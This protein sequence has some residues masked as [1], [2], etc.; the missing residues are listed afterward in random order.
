MAR[1]RIGDVVRTRVKWGPLPHAFVD[2]CPVCG[3]NVARNATSCSSCGASFEPIAEGVV[4]VV[5][6]AS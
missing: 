4:Q 1:P 6:L 5:S 3:R 2:R